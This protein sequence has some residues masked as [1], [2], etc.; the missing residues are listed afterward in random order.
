MMLDRK[1]SYWRVRETLLVDGPV[2][3]NSGEMRVKVNT[4]SAVERSR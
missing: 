1:E 2:V 3:E 4:R